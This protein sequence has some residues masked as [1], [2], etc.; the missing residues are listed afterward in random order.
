M[1]NIP[2]ELAI[3]QAA[4]GEIKLKEDIANASLDEISSIFGRDKSVISRHIKNIF[5]DEELIEEAVVAFFATTAKDGK[6][7]KVKYL[8]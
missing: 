8:I 1:N 6:T 7:Y 3:Y 5:K 4:N 2:K